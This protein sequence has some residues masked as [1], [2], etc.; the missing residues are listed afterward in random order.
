MKKLQSFVVLAVA[1][2]LA[3]CGK[4]NAEPAPLEFEVYEQKAETT[5]PYD[6][7]EWTETLTLCVD[8][9]LGEG[10]AQTN[11][12]KGIMEII[13]KSNLAKTLGAP[14]GNTL[15]EVVD[16]YTKALKSDFKAIFDRA[17]AADKYPEGDLNLVI[18]CTYQNEACVVMCV[19][20][21]RIG[22]EDVSRQYEG[23]IRLSDGHLLAEDE[24]ANISK[25]KLM[26]LAR[27][28][29]DEA[30]D[31]EIKEDGEYNI[32]LGHQALL[33]HPNQY[34][35]YEYAIPMEAVEEYLTE[36]AKALLTANELDTIMKVEPAKGDLAMYDVHGPVKELVI[37]HYMDGEA[38]GSTSYGFDTDG[39]LVSEKDEM[40]GE[41]L[42]DKLFYGRTNRDAQGR[43]IERFTDDGVAKEI[44]TFDE[45][46][47]LVK[48]EY[49]LG[50]R[51]ETRSVNYYDS[52][53]RLYKSN[54][55]RTVHATLYTMST[56]KY[57]DDKCYAYDDH[58]NWTECLCRK[59][60]SE[61]KRVI[62]YYE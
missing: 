39:R 40:G 57:F 3:A 13:S 25:E 18:R 2:L 19:E 42:D 23:V 44:N 10:Q 45:A 30:Q 38:Y 51:L 50:G 37:N 6:D 16:N 52:Q 24:I 20:D 26:E 5:I 56:T 62:T 47:W 61:D 17:R 31:M 1:V 54:E 29:A 34:S 11:A 58:G 14:T 46:G 4:E 48:H 22:S 15:K 12:I 28:Y 60:D 43:G 27:K 21:G 33:F 9:P 53:G 35:L 55:K 41:V 59:S 32:S 8:V 7:G 49:W 36:E